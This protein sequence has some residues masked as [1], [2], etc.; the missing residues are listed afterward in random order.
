VIYSTSRYYRY[1]TY[2]MSFLIII[3][4]ISNLILIPRYGI[5]GAAIA[6]AVSSFLYNLLR[7]LFLRI[8]FGMQPFSSKTAILLLISLI[9]Y[10]LSFVIPEFSNYIFDIIIRSTFITLIFGILTLVFQISVEVNSGFQKVIMKIKSI[11]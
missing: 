1:Q 9:S 6:S 8:R 10:L 7:F 4:V 2:F 5:V 11:L 3:V